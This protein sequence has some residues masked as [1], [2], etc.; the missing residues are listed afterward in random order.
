MVNATKDSYK[1]VYNSDGT[2]SYPKL[3]ENLLRKKGEPYFK[4]CEIT[5]LKRGTEKK[6]KV[7]LTDVWGDTIL[8]DMDRHAQRLSEGGRYK[9]VFVS[10]EDNAGPHTCEVYRA[11]KRLQFAMRGWLLFK[12]S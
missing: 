4:G 8:P 12:S 10:Q 5:G 11:F 9:V 6:P 2:Y 7:A 3:P 1:R